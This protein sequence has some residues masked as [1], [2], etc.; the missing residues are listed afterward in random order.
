MK[1][2]K[3]LYKD[4]K[5]DIVRLVLS[6][7]RYKEWYLLFTA[8]LRSKRSLRYHDLESEFNMLLQVGF[9]EELIGNKKLYNK[10]MSDILT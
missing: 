4:Y 7:E 8:R 3:V 10:I 1:H 9:I 2:L 5:P 6:Y